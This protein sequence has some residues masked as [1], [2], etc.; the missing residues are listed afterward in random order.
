FMQ[1]VK[2]TTDIMDLA[3]RAADRW[4]VS[5]GHAAVGPV[6]LDLLARGVEAGKGPLGAFVRPEQWKVWIP[7][8]ELAV[9]EGEG[10]EARRLSDDITTDGSSLDGVDAPREETADS[11]AS[12]TL[13]SQ[14]EALTLLMT[15]A[16]ARGAA[17]AAVV[18]EIDDDGAVAVC[19]HGPCRW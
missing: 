3:R 16:V 4:Y 7:P 8:S 18:H 14:R 11:W 13:S 9:I 17:D 15:A 10:G 6:K 5:V 1:N 19:A 12:P 2:M